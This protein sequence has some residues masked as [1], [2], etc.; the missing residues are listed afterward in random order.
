MLSGTDI[1][2]MPAYSGKL[3]TLIGMGLPKGHFVGLKVLSI[4]EP[5]LLLGILNRPSSISTTVGKSVTDT[6]EVGPAPPTRT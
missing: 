6:I 2:D 1:T 5:I 4:S 3:R